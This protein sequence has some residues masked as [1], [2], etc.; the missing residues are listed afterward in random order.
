M[1]LTESRLTEILTEHLDSLRNELIVSFARDL[2]HEVNGITAVLNTIK[3]TANFA[4]NKAKACEER[5]TKLEE[6][7]VPDVSAIVEQLSS[8][9]TDVETLKQDHAALKAAIDKCGSLISIQDEIIDDLRNRSMRSTLIFKGIEESAE[10]KSWE[11]TEQILYKKLREADPQFPDFAIE[12]CHRGHTKKNSQGPRDIICRFLNWKISEKVKQVFTIKNN[13][14]RSF[15]VYAGQKYGPL[16]TARRNL[17]MVERKRLL[18]NGEAAKAYVAYPAKL[19]VAVSKKDSKYHVATDFSMH[20]VNL[21]G[22][23]QSIQS[24]D[25]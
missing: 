24:A 2:K 21:S 18:A 13:R 23:V 10:E 5:I 11:D 7:V 14:D 25:G 15:K 8:S 9:E 20:R 1:T 16:T 12:R 6:V 4:L 17:A 19:M 3:T 22:K